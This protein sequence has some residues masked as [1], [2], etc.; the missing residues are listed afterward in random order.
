MLKNSILFGITC[1]REKYWETQSFKDLVVSHQQ[2]SK[3]V[4]LYICIYDNTDFENWDVFPDDHHYENVII[5]YH[6][7]SL[8]SGISAAFNYFA[9]LSK[10]KRLDWIVFLDQDTRLPI[11]F[12]TKYCNKSL[13]T[14]KNILFP[15]VY[16]G[17]HLFSPSHY[18]YFRTSEILGISSE[19]MLSGVTAINSG[20]MIKSS[21]FLLNGGYNQ[22][23]RVD[24]CDHEFIE[25]INN[26]NIFADI[27]D[28]SLY[29]EFSAKTNDKLKSIERY[30]IYVKD[31]KIYRKG[32]N[33]ILFFVRVDLPHLIKEI[34][35]NKS[36]EF[37]KIRLK[38]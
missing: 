1:F 34:Y 36:F 30:K 28:V 20:L 15:K 18:N 31:L 37:L 9:T 4:Q 24:F 14:G 26:K 22:N 33:K 10:H 21:F 5:D 23:L 8:N 2:I 7:D 6:R 13:A 29:Q 12:F 35:R 25:K 17:S 16:V 32:K 38:S 11:D 27:I 19:I 3:E